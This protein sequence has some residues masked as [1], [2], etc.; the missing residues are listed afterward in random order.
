MRGVG[1]EGRTWVRRNGGRV[2]HGWGTVAS[3]RRRVFR[4]VRFPVAC[5]GARSGDSGGGAAIERGALGTGRKTASC[6]AS[7][8]R[9][10]TRRRPSRTSFDRVPAWGFRAPF[11]R[12]V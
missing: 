9:C 4:Q 7:S 3:K 11:G 2:L 1:G 12:F 5:R 8:A 10:P 6:G